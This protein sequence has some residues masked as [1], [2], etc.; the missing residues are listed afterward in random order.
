MSLPQRQYLLQSA[1][2][3]VALGIPALAVTDKVQV[4][5]HSYQQAVATELTDKHNTQVELVEP[6]LVEL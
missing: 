5:D 1:A 3:E 2:E 6:D 4:L